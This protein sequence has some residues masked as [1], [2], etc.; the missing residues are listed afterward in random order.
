MEEGDIAI[1]FCSGPRTGASGENVSPP[2][3]G[4]QKVHTRNG[5]AFPEEEKC[6]FFFF[7]F[8]NEPITGTLKACLYYSL[9]CITQIFGDHT[10]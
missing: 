9:E 10:A 1:F 8:L 5:R 7:F 2:T 3:S 6:F 4:L